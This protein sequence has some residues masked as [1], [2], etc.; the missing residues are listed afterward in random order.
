MNT[1]VT[2]LHTYPTIAVAAGLSVVILLFVRMTLGPSRIVAQT[3]IATSETAQLQADLGHWADDL[4]LLARSLQQGR[5]N[6]VRYSLRWCTLAPPAVLTDALD[7]E[8]VSAQPVRSMR[9]HRILA[10]AEA[11]AGTAVRVE[12]MPLLQQPARLDRDTP[13]FSAREYSSAVLLLSQDIARACA[14]LTVSE[15][16]DARPEVMG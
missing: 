8:S 11:L 15:D 12:G 5:W 3:E 14:S 1:V 13:I 7:W 6:D 4:R 9:F 10:Q 16:F 2:F